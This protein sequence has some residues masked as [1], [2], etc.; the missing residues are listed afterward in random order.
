MAWFLLSSPYIM[1]AF[2]RK[3]FISILVFQ[4]LLPCKLF[5]SQK[6]IVLL[7]VHDGIT[8]NISSDLVTSL[9]QA[10]AERGFD[11]VSNEKVS[12][13][14][15]Y[16][17][18]NE[19]VNS[20]AED[21]V[22][23]AKEHYYNFDHKEALAQIS[24]AI[25]ILENNGQNISANGSML[26]DAY[27]TA[28]VIEKL[29]LKRDD[30]AVTN[31]KSAILIDP[32]YKLDEKGF[33]PTVI[34]LFEKVKSEM[35]D[36][37]SGTISVNTDPKAAEV[38]VNG[39]L[40]GLTPISISEPAGEYIVAIK[41]NKYRSFEKD[42]VV[43]AGEEVEIRQK[44]NWSG[45]DKR[46][47]PKFMESARLQV[48]EGARVAELLRVPKVILVNV[49][50]SEDGDGVVSMRMVDRRF[51]A[52]HNPVVIDYVPSKRGLAEDLTR[53]TKILTEQ[54]DVDI[55]K[56]PQKNLDPDGVGD[57]VL[58]GK[59][60]KKGEKSP[61]FWAVAGGALAAIAGGATAAV[62]MGGGGGSSS[63]TGNLNVRF[64]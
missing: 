11:V 56:N 36:L 61:V 28:G 64:K 14:V 6:P 57:P 45:V 42:V 60:K 22:I 39:I 21:A 5:A 31:F 12:A 62:M 38:F 34:S 25:K 44:L 41:T 24:R 43:K 32:Q 27:V 4:L 13:V 8:D 2:F 63:P 9:S 30:F 1:K 40:K 7:P 19:Q 46:N 37:P 33:S 18:N 54:Y 52:G 23:L 10:M 29:G 35:T 17:Q 50:G 58:L 53:A 26:R 51:K 15:S 16:Y 59:R 48:K 49:D 3:F 47:D 55:L 20:E